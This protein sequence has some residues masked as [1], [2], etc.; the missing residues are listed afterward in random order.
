[1]SHSSAHNTASY[2]EHLAK[3]LGRAG[4]ESDEDLCSE[5]GWSDCG[6]VLDRATDGMFDE[7]GCL[8]GDEECDWSYMA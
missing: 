5:A 2:F 4:S 7:W 8:G 1:M 6:P 3:S